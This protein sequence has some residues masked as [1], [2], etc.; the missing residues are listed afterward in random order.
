MNSQHEETIVVGGVHS[1][2]ELVQWSAFSS[3]IHAYRPAG[4]LNSEI[5]NFEQQKTYVVIIHAS[6]RL[7]IPVRSCFSYASTGIGV[8][9]LVSVATILELGH[10]K[11]CIIYITYT[12]G[13][14]LKSRYLVVYVQIYTQ[15][16][17]QNSLA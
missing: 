11:D 13:A 2:T 10:D 6:L 17:Y 14:W 12:T 9:L 15:P 4:I 8:P 5:V 16:T 7:A 1:I 3:I